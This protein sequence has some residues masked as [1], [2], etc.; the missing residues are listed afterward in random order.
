[1]LILASN[2]LTS[3]SLLAAV[4]PRLAG[5]KR[6]ALVV[7]ADNLYKSDNYHVPR[8]RQALEGL[9]LSVDLFD[10]DV[11]PAE[12][13][14]DFD[15]VECIGGNPFYLLQSIRLHRAGPTLA[16]LAER[17]LLI[18]WSAA[19]FVFG[20]TLALV[21][22]YSPELNTPGLT[23]L[24]ALALTDVQ[25]L[26]HYSRFLTRF[27]RFEETCA[28]YEAAHRCAVLRLNDGDGVLIDGD[29]R[30]LVRA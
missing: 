6:A 28:A 17:K 1:M 11:D 14:L 10:L 13:L 9:G 7:T 4:S 19:A 26:P 8:C 15:V 5:A 21:N 25:V 2:G 23:D 27:P 22:Q 18:G 24:A 16:A 30:T 29:A 20:P 12:R 3:Q